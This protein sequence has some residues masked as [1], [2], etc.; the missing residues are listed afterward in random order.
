VIDIQI[1][2]VS[3]KV[4][5][6]KRSYFEKVMNWEQDKAYISDIFKNP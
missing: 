4:Q 1:E 5:L 2:F 3:I 6:R